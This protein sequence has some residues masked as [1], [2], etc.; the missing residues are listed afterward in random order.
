MVGLLEK[1]E[2][3]NLKD[4]L[5]ATHVGKTQKLVEKNVNHVVEKK[6]KKEQN[7]Q[8]VDQHLQLVEPPKKVRAGVKKVMKIC[9]CQKI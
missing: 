2:K 7:I 6:V 5:I 4:G 8:H 9:Q 3:V 1:V